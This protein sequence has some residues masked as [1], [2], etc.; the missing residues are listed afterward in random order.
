MARSARRVRAGGNA[1]AGNAQ[2]DEHTAKAGGWARYQSLLIQFPMRMQVLQAGILAGAGNI[3]QQ[4]ISGQTDIKA[5]PVIQQVAISALVVAPMAI[6]WLGHLRR[7]KLPWAVA[8]A[9]DQ[10]GFCVLM[11]LVVFWVLSAAFRGGVELSL[12]SA[13]ELADPTRP[14]TALLT[15]RRAAFPSVWTYAPVWSTRVQALK[16]KLPATAV[17]EKFVPPHLKG[18]WEL[19]VSFVW[20]IMMAAVLKRA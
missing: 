18:V 7:W 12:P 4:L 9:V 11:N 17:R 6:W 1:A 13:S 15:L 16:L 19:A 2:D 20:N 8:T 14:L 5:S 3:A 10:L